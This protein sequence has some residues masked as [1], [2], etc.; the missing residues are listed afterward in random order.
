[1]T[2]VYW[3]S[4]ETAASPS[5]THK[6]W[7][8]KDMETQHPTCA[9]LADRHTAV[10]EGIRGMLET[11]F[12]AVYMVADLRT[13]KQGA[14]RLLPA[15]IVLD[16]SLAGR[17]SKKLMKEI[18]K[19]SPASR[20]LVLTLHDEATVARHALQAGAHGVVLKRCIGNDF[21]PAV[22][23]LLQGE[24]Y[25]SPDFGLTALIH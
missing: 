13:L 19:L 22:D 23:A 2:G 1:M 6:K 5:V 20:L 14:G 15:L 3:K 24:D 9:L 7:R 17:D 21:L 11:A 25:V 4:G 10:A 8:R 16:L 12:Q 18:I